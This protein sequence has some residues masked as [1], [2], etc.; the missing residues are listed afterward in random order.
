VVSCQQI[1]V[2][3]ALG[4]QSQKDAL[5]TRS[6]MA[7]CSRHAPRD[8][9]LAGNALRGKLRLPTFIEEVARIRGRASRAVRSRAE[10]GNAL[11]CAMQFA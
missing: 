7:T 10:P 8:E 4:T 3:G 6:V 2:P 1:L 9:A 11:V 5:I